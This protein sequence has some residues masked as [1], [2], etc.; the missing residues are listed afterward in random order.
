MQRSVSRPQT[1]MTPEGPKIEAAGRNRGRRAEN[2]GCRPVMAKIK[3]TGS[4]VTCPL[5]CL[6]LQPTCRESRA[7]VLFC[8]GLVTQIKSHIV[9]TICVMCTSEIYRDKVTGYIVVRT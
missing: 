1:E 4:V 5:V 3:R 6:K 2:G 9:G 7:K 8:F